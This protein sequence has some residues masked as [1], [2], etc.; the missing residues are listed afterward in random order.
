MKPQR[1]PYELSVLIVKQALLISQAWMH[2]GS[3][4]HFGSLLDEMVELIK[5]YRRIA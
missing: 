5:E 2:D 4:S 1:A 3:P